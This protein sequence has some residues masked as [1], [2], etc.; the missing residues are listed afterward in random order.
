MKPMDLSVAEVLRLRLVEHVSVRQIARQLNM[1]RAA[2]RKILGRPA[3]PRRP[4]LNLDASS[5]PMFLDD[6]RRAWPGPHEDR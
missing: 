2:V 4:R 5:A 1:A 3:A 6:T